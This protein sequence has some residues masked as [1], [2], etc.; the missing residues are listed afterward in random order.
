MYLLSIKRYL[1]DVWGCFH[2]TWEE[3]HVGLKAPEKELHPTHH[4]SSGE[5]NQ[6]LPSRQVLVWVLREHWSYI[7]VL[8]SVN[9]S[10]D[11]SREMSGLTEYWML[12]W[13][14]CGQLSQQPKSVSA[15]TVSRCSSF[16]CSGKKIQA[17]WKRTRQRWC[18]WY[19][20][21]INHLF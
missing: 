17:W 6:K 21:A 20:T 1:L 7:S 4:E 19:L 8:L 16:S 5:S 10:T 14:V 18:W 2:L 11:L 12:G 3:A 15:E 9:G 13:V